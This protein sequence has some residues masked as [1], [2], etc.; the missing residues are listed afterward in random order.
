MISII[1]YSLL[2]LDFYEPIC[3]KLNIMID[4]VRG[5]SLMPL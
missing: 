5:Y 1:M 3:K 4:I 2:A